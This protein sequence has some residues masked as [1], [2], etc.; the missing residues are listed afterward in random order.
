MRFYVFRFA[1]Q[2]TC[3][4]WT[5]EETFPHPSEYPLGYALGPWC[6]CPIAIVI[7]VAW[8]TLQVRLVHGACWTPPGLP[9]VTNY[10]P[11]FKYPTI[12]RGV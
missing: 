10:Y 12:N 9:F 6:V 3:V 1:Q 8:F 5:V 4:L 7:T 11:T 2:S